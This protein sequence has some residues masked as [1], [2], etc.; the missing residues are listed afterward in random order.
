[1]I[2]T[3]RELC[4]SLI[5]KGV[6]YPQGAWQGRLPRFRRGVAERGKNDPARGMRVTHYAIRAFWKVWRAW[7]GVPKSV[8]HAGH[9]CGKR[10]ATLKGAPLCHA[11]DFERG[12]SPYPPCGIGLNRLRPGH[13]C[14]LATEPSSARSVA[15]R[16][17]RDS[18]LN[19]AEGRL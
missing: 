13:G 1:M 17:K 16:G 7:Q 2:S 5:L 6:A 14:G 10:G 15:R 18:T 8:C 19:L 4:G 9:E 3:E 11:P 12:K